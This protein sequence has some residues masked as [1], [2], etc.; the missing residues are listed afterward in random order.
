MF[1]STIVLPPFRLTIKIY[2]C[3]GNVNDQEKVAPGSILVNIIDLH[4]QF[5]DNEILE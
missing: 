5:E 2:I 3:K 1:S 4:F